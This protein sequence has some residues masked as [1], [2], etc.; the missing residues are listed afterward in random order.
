MNDRL[1]DKTGNYNQNK[2][3]FSG[4]KVPEVYYFMKTSDTFP[5]DIN[6]EKRENISFA[7]RLRPE[8]LTS[9]EKPLSP[10]AFLQNMESQPLE[11]EG[12]DLEVAEACR[13]MRKNNIQN[14]ITTLDSL[15]IIP[16]D[17]LSL[18]QVIDI[19]D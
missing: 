19:C 15:E 9:Y 10:D 3:G 13:Y 1:K 4:K 12:E 16:I 2:V 14:L 11:S 7:Y 5:I 6:L 17:S 18:T 8:F